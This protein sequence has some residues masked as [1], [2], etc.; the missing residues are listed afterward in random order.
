MEGHTHTKKKKFPYIAGMKILKLMMSN[1][2]KNISILI[3]K[4][5]QGEVERYVQALK[6]NSQVSDNFW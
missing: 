6:A 3:Q 5:K 1:F 4:N 2:S